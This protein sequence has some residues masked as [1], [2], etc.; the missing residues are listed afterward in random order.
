MLC[1]RISKLSIPASRAA[2]SHSLYKDYGMSQSV[3]AAKLGIAQP[4]VYKYLNN[5]Y[6]KQVSQTVELIKSMGTYKSTVKEIATT[7]SV[8][9]ARKM[10][11]ALALEK[12][13]F[14]FCIILQ[15]N[16]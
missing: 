7:K 1:E 10:V 12:R 8:A 15:E 16:Q 14:E 6:S 13:V 2:I 3:I 9:K 4:A 5:R 11:E